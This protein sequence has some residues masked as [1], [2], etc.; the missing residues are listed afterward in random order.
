MEH[1]V[2][3][4]GVLDKAVAVLVA[5]ES[6]GANLGELVERTGLSRATAHRLASALEVHGIL[7]R[8]GDGRFALGPRLAA[9][10]SVAAAGLPLAD[11]AR[12]ALT[13]LRDDTGESAQLYVRD[14]DVR[15][16]VASLQSPHGLRTIVVTGAVLALAQGSGGRA[17]TGQIGSDGW[18]AS[19]AEREAGVASVSAPVLDRD[20]AVVAAVSV[21]GPVERLSQAPGPAYGPS[22]VAAA[23]RIAQEAGLA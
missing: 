17:L 7:R 8:R 12:P 21:S 22:V 16:C 1:T 23:A 9:L 4:V 10:G 13:A 19:V 18:V 6:D 11:A 3:G 15:V 20:G 14:G 5:I 2:S